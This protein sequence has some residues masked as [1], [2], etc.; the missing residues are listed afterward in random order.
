METWGLSGP[1]AQLRGKHLVAVLVQGTNHSDF[2]TGLEGMLANPNGYLN[3]V[4]GPLVG[5]QLLPTGATPSRTILSAH[6]GGGRA[7]SKMLESGNIPGNLAMVILL[8]ALNSDV[9]RDRCVNWVK[10][11]ISI[12]ISAMTGKPQ[13]DQLAYLAGSMRFFGFTTNTPFYQPF[14]DFLAKAI[15]DWIK[16]QATAPA[17]ASAT[18]RKRLADNYQVIKVGGDHDAII[19]NTSPA[20]QASRP[21]EFALAHLP[22][23]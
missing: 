10:A 4:F 1:V 14:Y 8:D 11:Q 21:I 6:S 20:L 18:V 3:E 5:E 23:P 16:S 15:G 17:V 19:G 22:S 2:G 12:D 7:V 13:A 9:Q